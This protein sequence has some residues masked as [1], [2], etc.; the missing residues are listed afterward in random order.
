M[1]TREN[2]ASEVTQAGNDRSACV[3]ARSRFRWSLLGLAVASL[4]LGFA[5]YSGLR[6]RAQAETTLG[7]ATERAAVPTVTVINPSAREEAEEIALPGATQAFIDTPIFARTNGY[8]RRWYFD[9][10]A[11]VMQGQLHA[12]RTCS[13]QTVFQSKRPTRPFRI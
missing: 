1:S 5:I 10:G 4:V 6:E 13:R 9:I 2:N 8:L 11:H 3:P 7:V 12:G